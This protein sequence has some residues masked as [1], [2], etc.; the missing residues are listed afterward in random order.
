MT[1]PVY[2]SVP[3]QNVVQDDGWSLSPAV[4]DWMF[5]RSGRQCITWDYHSVTPGE[6]ASF[7]FTDEALA[8]LFK[9]TWG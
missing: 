9:L 6:E 8:T 2:V 7:W 1:P 4:R 5:E 3:T